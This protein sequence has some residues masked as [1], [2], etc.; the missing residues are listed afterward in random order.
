MKLSD[1]LHAMSCLGGHCIKLR[2][3]CTVCKYGLL[4]IDLRS[5]FSSHQIEMP[6]RCHFSK[7]YLEEQKDLL[8]GC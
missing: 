3:H 6:G 5:V 2:D 7:E 4:C 1:A 8:E